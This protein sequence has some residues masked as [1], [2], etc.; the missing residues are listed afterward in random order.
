MS[1]DEISYVARLT[2]LHMRPGE[3][4][5]EYPFSRRAEYR[6]FRD[7]EGTGPDVTLLGLADHLAT[8]AP[9]PDSTGWERRGRTTHVLLEAFFRERNE[10]VNPT[11]LLNG[12]QVM[13]A[14]GLEPGPKV[15]ELLEAL[16]EAQA[17]GVVHT[18]GDALVWLQQKA[19][20]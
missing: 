15:G 16:L 7:A 13:Q 8:H 2:D 6:F 10:R 17:T 14:L 12:R 9:A 1:A 5:H 19:A 18:E 3:L 20:H 11:P 4:A